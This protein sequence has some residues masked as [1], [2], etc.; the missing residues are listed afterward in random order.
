MS[1]HDKCVGQ[2]NESYIWV[3]KSGQDKLRESKS[4]QDK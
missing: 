3:R 4:D 2:I 1:G